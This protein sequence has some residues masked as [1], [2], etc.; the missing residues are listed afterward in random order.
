MRQSG[1]VLPFR[2]LRKF[3]TTLICVGLDASLCFTMR[4]REPSRETSYDA[5]P[6]RVKTN[7][8]RNSSSG[9]LA[10]NDGENVVLTDII[11]SAW[12]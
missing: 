5:S 7:G 3:V 12:R 11:A 2:S 6:R 10:E 8:P 9:L 1:G 4:K